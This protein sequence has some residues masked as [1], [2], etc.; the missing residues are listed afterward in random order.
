MSLVR[1]A[2]I[3]DIDRI[4]ELLLQVNMVHHIARPDLFKGPVTK[5]SADELVKI[6]KDENTPVFVYEDDNGTVQGH[7]F[8]QITKPENTK[9]LTDIKSLH[10]GD[11]CVDE[12]ARGSRVGE[13]LFKYAKTFA[14]EAGCYNITLNVWEGNDGAKAFYEKCGLKP[15][16]YCM[17]MIL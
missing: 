3:K 7:C 10:I 16:K 13:S 9:L 6:I 2:E 11:I 8:A 14:T 1:K 5:Y 4:M 15:Q 17:E 12:K